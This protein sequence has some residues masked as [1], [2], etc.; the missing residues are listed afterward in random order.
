MSVLASAPRAEQP[1]L[2]PI[3]HG[4]ARL[5][6]CINGDVYKLRRQPAPRGAVAWSLVKATGERAGSAYTVIRAKGE[7][8]CTCYDR[9]F[10][11]RRNLP[12]SHPILLGQPCVLPGPDG[13]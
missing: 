2:A 12:I 13:F 8:A 10:S 9:R 4:S 1:A 11:R 6:L 7:V 5:V 3:R